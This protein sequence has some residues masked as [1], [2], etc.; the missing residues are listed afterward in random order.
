[1]SAARGRPIL[2]RGMTTP[3]RS[4]PDSEGMNLHGIEPTRPSSP[5]ARSGG[6][7]LES[8]LSRPSLAV[9][10]VSLA[11]GIISGGVSYLDR[12]PQHEAH[13]AGMDAFWQHVV[14]YTLAAVIAVFFLRRRPSGPAVLLAPLGVTAAQRLAHTLRA[15]LRHPT[16]LLRLLL[17]VVPLIM[18]VY[19][20]YRCGM[21]ILGGLDPNFTVNAW[22]GPTYLGA[23]AFHYADGA[24][25][26]AASAGLLNLLLLPVGRGD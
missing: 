20:P 9:A 5:S 17:A 23:M 25:L 18:L 21:Q 2:G 13:V 6:P 26:A 12:S 16:A 1:M 10:L 11:A 7:G 14:L 3:A 4:E 15:V 22:G 19:F 8:R 24:L